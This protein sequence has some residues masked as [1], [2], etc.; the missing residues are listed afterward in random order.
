PCSSSQ[1]AK[2][3]RGRSSSGA[4]RTAARKASR[5]HMAGPRRDGT[6]GASAVHLT[7][8]ADVGGRYAGWKFAPAVGR[9][10]E[11]C[12]SGRMDGERTKNQT[13]VGSWFLVLF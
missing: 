10:R 9:G 7:A 6:R 8:G 13:L 2:I 1:S 12:G 5:S 4:S 11:W 3:S